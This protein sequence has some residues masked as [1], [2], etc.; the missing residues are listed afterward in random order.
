[1]SLVFQKEKR[2]QNVSAIMR[3]LLMIAIFQKK[4]FSNIF[5]KKVKK[6]ARAKIEKTLQ[7]FRQIDFFHQSNLFFSIQNQPSPRGWSL[8]GSELTRGRAVRGSTVVVVCTSGSNDVG[9]AFSCVNSLISKMGTKS[10]E[11]RLSCRID[12]SDLTV[13]KAGNSNSAF[14]L[15]LIMFLDSLTRGGRAL[16]KFVFTTFQWK[17]ALTMTVENT[18]Y[19]PWQPNREYRM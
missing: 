19:R 12:G 9:D 13:S 16:I 5:H 3:I 1:M 8:S 15:R 11:M 10:G 17:L 4:K 18:L 14:F 6:L 2:R 7:F